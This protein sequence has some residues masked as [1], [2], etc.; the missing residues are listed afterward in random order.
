M[1]LTVN[2]IMVYYRNMRHKA[3]LSDPR[4][5]SQGYSRVSSPDDGLRILARLI[6]RELI[7]KRR[8]IG[9]EA[10]SEEM[11]THKVSKEK[12]ENLPGN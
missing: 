2:I 11:S 8:Q 5:I 1:V 6:A 10:S 12:R 7:N 3:I 4:D 9:V